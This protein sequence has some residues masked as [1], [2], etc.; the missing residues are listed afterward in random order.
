MP[1]TVLSVHVR[2]LGRPISPSLA[3]KRASFLLPLRSPKESAARPHLLGSEK[4]GGRGSRSAK[5]VLQLGRFCRLLLQLLAQSS[6]MDRKALTLLVLSL[7][8]LACLLHSQKSRTSRRLAGRIPAFSV[9]TGCS[10]TL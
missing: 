4:G 9:L 5:L 6:D 3:E 7:Q 10:D 8:L 1:C 2:T